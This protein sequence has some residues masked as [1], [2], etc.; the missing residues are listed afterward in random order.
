MITSI[1]EPVPVKNSVPGRSFPWPPV[2]A[3]LL[4]ALICVAS[5]GAW[6]YWGKGKSATARG[7]WI[8]FIS[9]VAYGSTSD[10]EFPLAKALID[11]I[12][13][14]KA[15]LMSMRSLGRGWWLA[16]VPGAPAKAPILSVWVQARMA[17]TL[18]RS[19]DL[20]CIQGP[21]RHVE[22]PGYFTPGSPAE[23]EGPPQCFMLNVRAALP[24]KTILPTECL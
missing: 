16:Q 22:M 23:P 10:S 24:I 3:V 13:P 4:V 15:N 6:R 9:G 18:C 5:V 11:S 12:S 2:L 20:K 8:T 7:S 14:G 19:D 21:S 17:P 1:E